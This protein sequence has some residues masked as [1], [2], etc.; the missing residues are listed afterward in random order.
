MT[1]CSAKPLRPWRMQEEK[2]AAIELL[3]DA[4]EPQL[5]LDVIARAGEPLLEESSSDKLHQWLRQAAA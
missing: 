4:N 2:V 5:A 1:N 3:F